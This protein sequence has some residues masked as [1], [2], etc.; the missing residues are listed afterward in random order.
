MEVRAVTQD[1]DQLS[2]I[3]ELYEAITSSCRSQKIIQI[4]QI[5]QNE[6]R[7]ATYDDKANDT[8]EIGISKP[9]YLAMFKQSHDY[10]YRYM[11]SSQCTLDKLE[12]TILRE[13]YLMTLGYL[14]TANDHHSI[15]NLHELIVQILGNFETDIEIISCF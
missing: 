3:R 12:I 11:E 13:L 1:N 5:P 7:I 14:I 4:V 6:N 15:M 9:T 10:W 2:I 8:L